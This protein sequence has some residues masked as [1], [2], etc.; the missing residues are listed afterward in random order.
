[1]IEARGS[2]C[3]FLQSAI[4]S[5]LRHYKAIQKQYHCLSDDTKHDGIFVDH[6]LRDFIV[7]YRY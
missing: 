2:V 3:S 5:P 7:H 6:M 1:M 4:H